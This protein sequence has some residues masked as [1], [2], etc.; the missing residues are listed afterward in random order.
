MKRRSV[1]GYLDM[2][3]IRIPPLPA[4]IVL[5]DRAEPCAP[6]CEEEQCL[7][8]CEFAGKLWLLSYS[9][10][11]PTF[12]ADGLGRIS[13]TDVLPTQ[14][15]VVYPAYGE[16][17][18]TEEPRLRLIVRGGRIGYE[19]VELGQGEIDRDQARLRVRKAGTLSSV[20]REI[21][22]PDSW[23]RVP[24]RIGFTDETQ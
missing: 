24:D 7:D 15:Y 11:L 21:I 17:Y 6:G 20:F 9:T 4:S 5:T 10:S 22:V 18:L 8:G 13:I 12:T 14:D 23:E 3:R 16:P 1:G 2:G 19:L